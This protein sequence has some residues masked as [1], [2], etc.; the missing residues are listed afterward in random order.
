M[1]AVMPHTPPLLL[2]LLLVSGGVGANGGWAADVA[3][4]TSSPA[5]GL[6]LTPSTAL[7]GLVSALDGTPVASACHADN[8]VEYDSLR[9]PSRP[10]RQRRQ[11]LI[12]SN[13]GSVIRI[14]FCR[15]CAIN[16]VEYRYLVGELAKPSRQQ[17][18]VDPLL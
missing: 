11:S 7:Y 5:F 17:E 3:N 12:A 6:R 8:P 18:R 10:R 15:K 2:L 13:S 9:P 14:S 1:R 4:T 16:R